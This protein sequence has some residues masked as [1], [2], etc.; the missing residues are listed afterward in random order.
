MN[1]ALANPYKVPP[2]PKLTRIDS[3]EKRVKKRA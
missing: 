3:P 1:D 2:P